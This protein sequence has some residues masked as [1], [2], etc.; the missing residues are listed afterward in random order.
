[1]R[2][3][4][5]CRIFRQK[6]Y[7]EMVVNYEILFAKTQNQLHKPEIACKCVELGI[8]RFIL[9]TK[10]ADITLSSSIFAL[11]NEHFLKRFRFT[12]N[13]LFFRHI[14]HPYPSLTWPSTMD[15][16]SVLQLNY[17]LGKALQALPY[18]AY[19]FTR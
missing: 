14:K 13:S 6:S 3:R 11:V 8:D 4:I 2:T 16:K 1:M 18:P 5:D 9:I 12:L 17:R 19:T 10:L 15:A 7:K